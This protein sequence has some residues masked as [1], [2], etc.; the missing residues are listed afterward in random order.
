MRTSPAPLV[1]CL[2]LAACA[3][4]TTSPEAS[5]QSGSQAPKESAPQSSAPASESETPAPAGTITLAFAGDVHFERQVAPLL[6]DSDQEWATRL[7]ELAAADFA[8]LNLETALTERGTA[9]NKSYTFRTSPVALDKLAAAGIDAVSLANNHAA[10]F[11]RVGVQ[12]TLAAKAASPI[13][14]VGFGANEA[15]AYAPLTVDVKGVKVG[16]LASMEVPEET[17][18]NWSAGPDSPGVAQNIRRDRFTKAAE[19]AVAQHDLVV[20]FLH[21]GTEGTT[22]PNE[23]QRETVRVLKDA[24]VDIIVGTH[25]HR[26]QGSGWNGR[27]FVGYGTGNFIWY[28]TSA[29]SKPS[30]V[31]TVEVDAAA[32]HERGA[33]GPEQRLTQKSLVTGYTWHPK[34]I[35]DNG[36]PRTPRDSAARLERLA[37]AAT[38]C[39]GLAQSPS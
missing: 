37:D 28:N 33:A 3:G 29:D 15:E 23:R 10:D 26:P 1:L 24:G 32:A 36:I 27:T 14:I 2:A 20:A 25:A 9:Q 34:L 19:D 5:P 31:L 8:M 39:S 22:C 21:W 4:T 38:R 35:A 12:D 13:P 11:G 16:V 6:Q 17:Y 18:A 7:P 30:G